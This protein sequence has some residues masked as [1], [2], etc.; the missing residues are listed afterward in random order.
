M[1]NQKGF[2][3]SSILIIG[4]VVLVVY[5]ILQSSPLFK[6]SSNLDSKPQTSTISSTPQPIDNTESLDPEKPGWKI[7][8]N[9]QA[10]YQISYPGEW[11]KEL[12]YNYYDADDDLTVMKTLEKPSRL[13]VTGELQMSAGHVKNSEVYSKVMFDEYDKSLK[14]PI[15]SSTSSKVGGKLTKVENIILANNPGVK[16]SYQ[17]NYEGSIYGLVHHIKVNETLYAINF[18][19]PDEQ[20][21]D[22]YQKEINKILNSFKLLSN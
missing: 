9:S 18:F 10:N 22:S 16:F 5:I 19:A 17:E 6:N 12:A 7:Y 21:L 8:K 4:I 13:T 20:T 11:S 3:L 1:V 14:D 15:G 2:S